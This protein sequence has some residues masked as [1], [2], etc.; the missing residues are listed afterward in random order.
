MKSSG[1]DIHAK[2]SVPGAG[3]C[4]RRVHSNHLPVTQGTESAST[5]AC[6]VFFQGIWFMPS[7]S[8]GDH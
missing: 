5:K 1:A 2:E 4:K 7:W 6:G 3:S 8:S